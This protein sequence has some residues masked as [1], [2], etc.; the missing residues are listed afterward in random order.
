[1]E[2]SRPSALAVPYRVPGGGLLG[3]RGRRVRSAP[4]RPPRL[5]SRSSSAGSRVLL[6]GRP[7]RGRPR[8]PPCPAVPGQTAAA[9][10]GGRS[11]TQRPARAGC[12]RGKMAA[13]GLK[14]E[15]ADGGRR[16]KGRAVLPAP[17][18]GTRGPGGGGAGRR[19]GP[20]RW[21]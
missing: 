18:P 16:T 4:S 21:V 5:S 12:E 13:P 2:N 20:V 6:P 3:R 14:M 17:L 19:G 10:R 7:S 8:W 11:E 15:D 9:G 1:M